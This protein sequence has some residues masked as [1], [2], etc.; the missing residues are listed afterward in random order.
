M[1]KQSTVNVQVS[2]EVALVLNS[3]WRT[4]QANH[5]DV[6]DVFLVVK[7]TGRS[8]RRGST[9]LGHYSYSEW[10]IE[11]TQA[12]EVMISGECFKGGPEQVLQTLLHEAAHGLAHVREVKDC[13]RQNRYHNKRFKNLAEE[14]GLEWPTLVD[15]QMGLFSG[16]PYPPDERIG[17]SSVRLTQ[18]TIAAYDDDLKALGT[19]QVCTGQRQAARITPGPKRI[20]TGCGC[21]EITFGHTQ[22]GVVAPLVC[23]TCEGGYKRLPRDMEACPD[24][25]WTFALGVGV[26]GGQDPDVNNGFWFTDEGDMVDYVDH[27]PPTWAKTNQ[28]L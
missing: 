14:M 9:T 3:T 18:E 27:Y 2:D 6:P 17:Y 21:R 10:A 7:S 1:N 8:G 23:G 11:E 4:I 26:K 19:L 12:P 20:L 13:S 28:G 16:F 24:T 25:G 15:T 22:W 5:P